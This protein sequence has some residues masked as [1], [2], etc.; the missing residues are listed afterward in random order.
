MPQNVEIKARVADL[1][2]VE[3]QASRIATEGPS[4]LAR[5]DT[6]FVCVTGRLKL[7]EFSSTE[8]QLIY[9]LRP[10]ES[11]SEGQ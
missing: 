8:G 10:N 4:D 6:Y 11:W 7:R 5:D 3:A 2:N 1:A 9:Y